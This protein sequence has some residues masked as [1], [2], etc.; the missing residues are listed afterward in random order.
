MA[1]TGQVTVNQTYVL[2]VD[3]DPSVSGVTAPQ[4]SLAIL[5]GGQGFWQK[6]G[7]LD[8]NW[9]AVGGTTVVGATS[10]TIF[11]DFLFR[12]FAGHNGVLDWAELSSGGGSSGTLD[13]G[14]P[15]NTSSGVVTLACGTTN[16]GRQ[17]IESNNGINRILAGGNQTIEWRVQV[18]ALSTSAQRYTIY[19][20]LRDGNAAGDAANSICFKY[21]DNLNS[22]QW[23]GQ[24]RNAS[25]STNVNSSVAVAASAWYKL[26]FQVNAGGTNVDFYVNDV[27][28]GSSTT[29]IPTTN[30]MRFM[31]MIEKSVGTTNV[32][33]LVDSLYY[34]TER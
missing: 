30:P 20:G 34:R 32:N 10:H 22:G 11:E 19:A 14:P 31:A 16:T 33:Y 27:Y 26:R 23:L 29:N 13:S 2:E 24:T 9:Q 17:T 21:S 8:T 12:D 5:Q 3:T 25:T 28:I 4:G 6:I 18:S 1:I 7:A 15:D